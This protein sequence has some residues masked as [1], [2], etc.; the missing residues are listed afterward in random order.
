MRPGTRRAAHRG[1]TNRRSSL[2]VPFRLPAAAAILLLTLLAVP[3]AGT[4]RAAGSASVAVTA[5][6]LSSSNCRF[7]GARPS[8][9]FGNLDPAAAVDVTATAT[10][11]FRCGGSSPV[12]TY[13]VTDDDGLYETGPDANRMR[14]AISPAEFIPYALSLDSGPGSIPRN[15]RGT[16]TITGTV[17]GADYRDAA[18]GSY[19]DSVVVSIL[20]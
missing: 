17:R 12:A 10:V 4:C 8:L 7:I 15:V 9:A 19:T 2:P 6:V 11:D 16:L 14:H 1:E 20:P 18:A 13:A 3:L 5:T